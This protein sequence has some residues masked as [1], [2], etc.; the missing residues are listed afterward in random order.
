MLTKNVCAFFRTLLQLRL[1]S[2][3]GRSGRAAICPHQTCIRTERVRQQVPENPA[4]RTGPA[5][6]DRVRGSGARFRPTHERDLAAHREAAPEFLLF[7][8]PRGSLVPGSA[9]HRVQRGHCALCIPLVPAT[10]R[11]RSGGA[12]DAPVEDPTARSFARPSVAVR[13][14]RGGTVRA[15]V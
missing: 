12:R 3:P 2:A 14:H 8:V 6:V 15:A 4:A 5:H 7:A 9:A 1:L 13:C 10:I 11:S